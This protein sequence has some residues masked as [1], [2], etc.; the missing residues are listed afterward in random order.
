MLQS[1]SKSLRKVVQEEDIRLAT[2]HKAVWEKLNLFPYK[3]T[4]VQELKPADHKCTATSQCTVHSTSWWWAVVAP[5]TC[6]GVIIQ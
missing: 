4:V 6:R 3:V 1:P 2:V 5:E